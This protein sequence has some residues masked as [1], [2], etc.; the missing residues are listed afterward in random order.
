[1]RGASLSAKNY[2]YLN[3][4]SYV[5]VTPHTFLGLIN[6]NRPEPLVF[7]DFKIKTIF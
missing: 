6:I 5:T 1:M 2:N 4:S 3:V 7:P